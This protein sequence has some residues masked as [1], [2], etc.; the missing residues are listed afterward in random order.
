MIFKICIDSKA[1]SL[2]SNGFNVYEFIS[3]N[4]KHDIHLIEFSNKKTVETNSVFLNTTFKNK[5]KSVHFLKNNKKGILCNHLHAHFMIDTHIG[6]LNDV[7]RVNP[8]IKTILFGKCKHDN[9][10][11][12]IAE[13]WENVIDILNTTADFNSDIT[14]VEIEK[15]CYYI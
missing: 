10:D 5:V 14:D 13:T 2:E 8:Y 12:L 15:L 6:S 4:S 9:R 3:V 7:K 1:V 11:H